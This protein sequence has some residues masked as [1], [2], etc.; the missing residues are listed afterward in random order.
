MAAAAIESRTV[1]D[2][3]GLDPPKSTSKSSREEDHGRSSCLEATELYANQ[4]KH[5][6]IGPTQPFQ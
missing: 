4:C 2:V 3:S 5:I 1:E 6:H